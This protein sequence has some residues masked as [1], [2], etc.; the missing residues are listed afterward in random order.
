MP[1]SLFSRSFLKKESMS[2]KIVSCITKS[3]PEKEL[4]ESVCSY[5]SRTYFRVNPH[6]LV[7]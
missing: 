5:M 2:Y 3:F 4:C 1:V 7:A 6:S